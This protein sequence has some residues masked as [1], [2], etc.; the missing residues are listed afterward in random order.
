MDTQNGRETEDVT[1]RFNLPLPKR[2]TS[3]HPLD[4]KVFWNFNGR[5]IPTDANKYRP[6]FDR[7]TG[8]IS[9]DIRNLSMK[10]I[11]SYGFTIITPME[12]FKESMNLNV[13]P[14][15]KSPTFDRKRR[16]F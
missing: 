8:E 15:S 11:G 10:D 7:D 14:I 2:P 16:E 12:T 4:L 6:K 13:I 5:P 1:L 9:L 3:A